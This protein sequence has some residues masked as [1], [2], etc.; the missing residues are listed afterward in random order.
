MVD[1]SFPYDPHGALDFFETR[2]RYITGPS[3]V[4]HALTDQAGIRL[5]DVRERA[6]YER[7]HIPG[8]ISLPRDRWSSTDGLQREQTNIVYCYG[9]HCQLVF[10]AAVDFARAGFPVRVMQGGFKAWQDHLYPVTPP[11]EESGAETSASPPPG[12]D[13]FTETRMQSRHSS[14]WPHS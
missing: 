12:L 1:L 3:D 7:G 8:A 13:P 14:S 5:V 9:E 10:L 4:H 2:S 11:S 6:D